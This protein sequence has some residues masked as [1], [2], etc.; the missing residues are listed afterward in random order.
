MLCRLDSCPARAILF[1][2][3]KFVITNFLE[4]NQTSCL[5]ILLQLL[6]SFQ[7]IFNGNAYETAFVKK[8]F[9]T[10]SKYFSL[11][12]TKLSFKSSIF[13]AFPPHK[14]KLIYPVNF[15]Q[16]RLSGAVVPILYDLMLHP[17]LTAD[18][19]G[20]S[21]NVKINLDVK[22]PVSEIILHSHELNITAVKFTAPDADTRVL[23]ISSNE[24]FSEI[25]KETFCCGV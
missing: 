14:F 22:A 11:F 20:F 19:G 12:T 18:G 21:G 25:L 15:L 3:A 17:D 7:S 10:S 23:V 6:L 24:S 4:T 13:D 2:V 5:S 9:V 1:S 16:L 8:L